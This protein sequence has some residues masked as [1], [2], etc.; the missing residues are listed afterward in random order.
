[1]SDIRPF[2][3]TLAPQPGVR[4]FT[5]A[6]P[7]SVVPVGTSP[8]SPRPTAPTEP[9]QPAI[10]VAAIR[11]EAEEQGRDEGLRETE[12]LRAKLAQMIGAL[13]AAQAE[14]T[15]MHANLIADA[16]ATVVDAWLGSTGSADKFLP[17]VRA[18]Q[19]RSADPATAHVHPSEADTLRAA[20]GES[21]LTV[22]A[23]ATI[24][25]G[26]LQ[27]RGPAHELTHSWERRLSE[28]REAITLALEVKS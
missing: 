28:L 27:L 8:W 2:L 1:M 10:D 25:V 5:S 3:S 13:A 26:T 6:L 9:A 19:A 18:W 15:A 16:A 14:A 4:P 12:V 20:I 11:A 24:P 22:V 17:L 7:V 21:T 23:D